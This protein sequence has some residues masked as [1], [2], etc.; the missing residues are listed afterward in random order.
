[1]RNR[2]HYAQAL[3]AGP[4]LALSV[5]ALVPLLSLAD[6]GG[7]R[8]TGGLTSIYQQELD[9]D[10]DDFS[11][12][13]D[14]LLTLPKENGHWTLYLEGASGT[15]AGSIFNTY[16]EINGDAG[17][18]LDRDGGGHIQ[19]SE[20]YYQFDLNDQ[21]LL[22]VGQI[23]ASAHVDRSRIS[24]DENTQFM[25]TSFINNPTIEFPDYTLGALYRR[26]SNQRAPELTFAITASDGIADNP[27]RSYRELIDI[28]GAGKGLFAT[29]AARWFLA[30]AEIGAGVWLRT[31]NHPRLDDETRQDQNYGAF[32]VYGVAI[33][34]QSFNVRAGVANS[35]VSPV[36]RFAG[37][38]YELRQDYGTFGL[39]LARIVP[40]SRAQ[41]PSRDDTTHFEAWYRLPMIANL[42]H[43]TAD[44]QFVRNPGFDG[45]G[46]TAEASA[47]V[48][49][50]RLD[51]AF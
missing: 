2:H 24:N 21:S 31:D 15:D 38:A 29:A 17:S 36:A 46:M 5:L 26:L 22:I 37:I 28:S 25:G 16:P 41:T 19:V 11:V 4:V 14:L 12:S 34:E 6:G 48:A 13:G 45:S 9:S 43:V 44:V 3:A 33:G 40:S 1:M 35:T 18:V 10:A 20:L 47:L 7:L 39:G 42:L 49:G 27:T 8:V 23:D 32:F 51:Y 50:L 30:D